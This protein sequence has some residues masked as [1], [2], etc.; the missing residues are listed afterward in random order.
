MQRFL[1]FCLCFIIA[2]TASAQRDAS[3]E[4][5]TAEATDG[6]TLVGEF[7]AAR[8]PAPSILLLHMLGSQ[9]SAWQPLVP[10]LARAG[11]N[12]LA[13]DLRG[14]GETRGARNW[15]LAESDT[16]TWIN[17]LQEQPTS[18]TMPVALVGASIGANLALVGCAA[19]ERC[20]TA[21]AL[22]PGLDFQGVTPEF[23][24]EGL[25][26]RPVLLVASQDDTT[27]AD[28][29]KTFFFNARGELGAQLYPGTLHGT[30]LLNAPDAPVI[31]LISDWLTEYLPIE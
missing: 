31:D 10:I 7:Y 29:V 23:A 17:W 27:S 6:L 11:Y 20:A 3:A 9:R 16:E 28:A 5:V 19:D 30:A 21:I 2:M 25:A 8:E 18:E 1:I 26:D 12:I 24:I 15:S 13:V 14:H 4:I 22:S